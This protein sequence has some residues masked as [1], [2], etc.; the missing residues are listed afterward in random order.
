M[1]GSRGELHTCKRLFTKLRK[2]CDRAP[3]LASAA[4]KMSFAS[5]GEGVR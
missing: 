1:T 2:R 4:N 3:A 5:S